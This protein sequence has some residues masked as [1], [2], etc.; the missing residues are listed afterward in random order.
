MS[1]AAPVHFR[2]D[3]EAMVPL[4]PAHADKV[5]VVGETYPLVVNEDRSANSHKHYHACVNEAW[6]NLPD[7]MAV[8]FATPD[9]LRKAALVETGYYTER[10]LICSSPGEA[11]KVAAFMR[12]G[13]EY[14]IISVAG[15]AVIERKPKSQSYRAMPKGEFQKSKTDVLDYLAKLIGVETAAL[16]DNARHAA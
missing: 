4:R 2:W 15:C 9:H 7:H 3:G 8:E 5:F 16:E 1:Q 10:R 6:R 11:R 12:A 14:A 13:E